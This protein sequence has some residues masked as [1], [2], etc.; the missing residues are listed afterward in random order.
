MLRTSDTPQTFRVYIAP[1][2]PLSEWRAAFERI[3]HL[4][5]VPLPS[6][7]TDDRGFSLEPSTARL[8]P[9]HLF[10]LAAPPGANPYAL[11]QHVIP[12]T[13]EF[14]ARHHTQLPSEVAV[15][16]LRRLGRQRYIAD[17]ALVVNHDEYL[18]AVANLLA[19]TAEDGDGELLCYDAID[20]LAQQPPPYCAQPVPVTLETAATTTSLYGNCGAY[21]VLGC[22]RARPVPSATTTTTTATTTLHVELGCRHPPLSPEEEEEVRQAEEYYHDIEYM[23]EVARDSATS[24]EINYS[25]DMSSS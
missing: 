25:D 11:H 12:S 6:L 15:E 1:L 2:T 7:A 24:D 14:Y 18:I 22:C 13:V 8:V 17:L 16:S 9:R 4:R 10:A 21:C 23:R 5:A 3:P 19:P 20:A